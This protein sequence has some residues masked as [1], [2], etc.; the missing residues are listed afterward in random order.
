MTNEQCKVMC[1]RFAFE[2]LG[3]EF[4]GIT[5]PNTCTPKCD[6]VYPKTDTAATKVSA[7]HESSIIAPKKPDKAAPNNKT[8]P[9]DGNKK[10][11]LVSW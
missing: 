5:H 7:Q 4:K 8:T 1:Q 6:S 9:S 3:K 2:A 10:A 11:Q